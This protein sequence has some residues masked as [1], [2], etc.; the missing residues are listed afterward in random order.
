MVYHESTEYEIDHYDLY[1]VLFFCEK[2]KVFG[3][4]GEVEKV[5]NLGNSCFYIVF[6][7]VKSACKA[8]KALNHFFVSD[9]RASMNITL[10]VE[11][12][13]VLFFK[14]LK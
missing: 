1:E 5:I 4:F 14:N 9:I 10:L 11:D 12:E 3:Y 8:M 6:M 13:F 7:E 2:K